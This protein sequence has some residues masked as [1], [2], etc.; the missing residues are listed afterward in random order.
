[1]GTARQCA[2]EKWQHEHVLVLADGR[3]IQKGDDDCLHWQDSESEGIMNRRSFLGRIAAGIAGA[4]LATHL[5]FGELVP[6][7]AAVVTEPVAG[8]DY[9]VVQWPTQKSFLLGDFSA[10]EA[11]HE[12]VEI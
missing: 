8:L 12:Q 4:A 3:T 9:Y 10:M 6:T 11:M 7:P 5:K 2:K 1:M